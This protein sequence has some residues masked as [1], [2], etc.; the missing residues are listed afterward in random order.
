MRCSRPRASMSCRR[1]F[2]STSTRPICTDR[3]AGARDPV[4]HEPFADSEPGRRS[5]VAGVQAVD[6]R[7]SGECLYRPSTAPSSKGEPS[8]CRD[9]ENRRSG[10]E[11]THCPCRQTGDPAR[12]GR[13]GGRSTV[14]PQLSEQRLEPHHVRIGLPGAVPQIRVV[15][16]LGLLH[17]CVLIAPAFRGAASSPDAGS[18]GPMR[19]SARYAPRSPV[20]TILPPVASPGFRDRHP[21]ASG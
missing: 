1:V 7:R 13:K 18:R 8:S 9:E 6:D 20:L 14:L 5:R 2:G 12:A 16:H 17:G 11:R 19:A 10:R 15:V 3:D 21:G 4:G